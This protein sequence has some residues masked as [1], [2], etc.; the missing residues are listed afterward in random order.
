[1][2][3]G[4]R[5]AA[6]IEILD[7]ILSRRRAAD[8]ALQEWA[9]ARR[10]AGSSD[11]RAIEARVFQVLRRRNECAAMAA[12]HM[13][14]RALVIGALRREGLSAQDISGLFTDGPHAPGPLSAAELAMLDTRPAPEDAPWIRLNTPE[15]LQPELER[16]LGVALEAELE[17]MLG[18]APLDVRVNTLRTDRKAAQDALARHGVTADA[19]GLAPDALRLR[20]HA[21]LESL[22]V[23]RDGWIEVQDIGS[24]AVC[25]ML[26]ARA[27][28]RV[29]DLCA[30]A[31]GKSLALA[32]RM[33]NEGAVL[34]CDVDGKRLGRLAP[35]AVR[36]GATMIE[37]TGDPYTDHPHLGPA[38]ADAVL[39]DAPCSG[40][41]TW[42]RN[43]E[44]KWSLDAARLEGYRAAQAQALDRAAQ[45]VRPGGR[46]LYVTCS[47]LR[48]EG[49]DQAESF[50]ARMPG[51]RLTAQARFSPAATGT[52]GFYA[53]LFRA[54]PQ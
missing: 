44:A 52:D 33:R 48:C 47:L 17:A 50:L 53:A 7:V 10:F 46:V 26:D 9:R 40:S 2:T 32:A 16:S 20:E 27:G 18:R 3:P 51:L 6:A 23:Y 11:R 43:P 1:M 30:G 45:L 28:E 4:A 15:W 14:P 38:S 37:L 41:G 36:C 8:L 25:E 34:A 5:L 12:G 22:D 49:E 35:R 42:R 29:V 39:V 19:S 21:H 54:S 24:Q 13:E 31:G